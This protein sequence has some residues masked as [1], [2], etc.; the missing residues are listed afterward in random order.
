MPPLDVEP[1]AEELECPQVVSVPDRHYLRLLDPAGLLLSDDA[2]A[3]DQV[4]NMYCLIGDSPLGPFRV[5]DPARSFPPTHANAPM[6]GV[7][8]TSVAVTTFSARSGAT[9]ATEFPTPSRSK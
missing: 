2:P 1:F 6:P 3:P 7:S 8:S 5:A 4:G 9:P